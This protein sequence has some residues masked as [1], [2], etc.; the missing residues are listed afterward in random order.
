LRAVPA[1]LPKR[2]YRTMATNEPITPRLNRKASFKERLGLKNTKF[3]DDM[4]AGRIPPPDGWLGPR[5]PVWTEATVLRTI[6]AYLAQPKPPETH[7]AARRRRKLEIAK[8]PRV[9]LNS[10]HGSTSR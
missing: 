1:L 6:Q 4:N 3:H 2:K 9:R 8:R 7:P 10:T 5:S